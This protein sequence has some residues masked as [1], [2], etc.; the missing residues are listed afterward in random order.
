MY[1]FN[2]KKRNN[3][4]NMAAILGVFAG[5]TGVVVLVGQFMHIKSESTKKRIT[6]TRYTISVSSGVESVLASFRLAEL[7]YIKQASACGTANPFLTALKEGANCTGFGTLDLF[8]E[9]ECDNPG[10]KPLCLGRI[11]P[12]AAPGEENMWTYS[13][14][15][16]AN[17]KCTITNTGSTCLN[18]ADPLLILT[19]GYGGKDYQKMSKEAESFEFK[20][21]GINLEKGIAEFIATAKTVDGK[22]SKHAFAIKTI[23]ANAAH[24]EADG[25]TTQEV[26]DPLGFCQGNVWG[27]YFALADR[28]C[29]PFVELG[30]GTG[31]LYYEGQYFGFR[32]TDGQ[33]I[34]MLAA[35]QGLG[36]LVAED[37]KIAGRTRVNCEV[38]A[39]EDCTQ[40]FPE[41]S[42][43]LLINVDD[44]TAI[45]NQ[46][47]YVAH[48]GPSAH[49]GYLK[50]GSSSFE[51][52]KICDLGG[53][54]WA[55]AYAGIA[56]MSWSDELDGPGSAADP[57]LA[58]FFLKTDAGD[59]LTV[60]IES[61]E[62][63][64][65]LNASTGFATGVTPAPGDP[66]SDTVK[67]FVSKDS[68]IQQ[69]EYK[70]TY[71]F[72]RTAN[73]KPYYI[74]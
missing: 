5:V 12:S 47:Y 1:F 41:Y 21:T 27:T 38:T 51:R 8:D 16:D 4:G 24:I 63:G 67:C 44:L 48:S 50:K 69:V 71:G 22:E 2:S 52:V 33:V 19:M 9:E 74:Y 65:S 55:Q 14:E 73:A 25:R 57:R 28:K 60:L 7:S 46:I 18:L 23:L 35:T 20:L 58:R 37:G 32:P 62:S 42:K 13:N 3:R 64:L 43:D 15:V 10:A 61:E 53:K 59:L 39:T 72:D 49:I 66:S 31:L 29:I 11:N 34:D 17:R 56:A 45:G 6:E 70:R 36:Y 30:S 68:N 40:L 54:G 26:P